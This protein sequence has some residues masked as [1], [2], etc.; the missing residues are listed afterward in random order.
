MERLRNQLAHGNDFAAS[1]AEAAAVCGLIH[2]MDAWLQRLAGT[3]GTTQETILRGDVAAHAT[4]R[5]TLHP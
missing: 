4:E 2:T 1:R 5:M 3:L